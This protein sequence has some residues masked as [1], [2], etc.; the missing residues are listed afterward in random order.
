MD[1]GKKTKGVAKIVKPRTTLKR[2][3][4]SEYDIQL[5][6]PISPTEI[7]R[8]KIAGQWVTHKQC[9]YMSNEYMGNDYYAI[10]FNSGVNLSS[11][12]PIL[13]QDDNLE[14]GI[15]TWVILSLNDDDDDVENKKP[16]MYLKK[17]LS[18]YEFGTKHQEILYHITCKHMQCEKYKLYYAGE[19]LKTGNTIKF[20]LESGTYMK[21]KLNPKKITMGTIKMSK[22][23]AGEMINERLN[24]TGELTIEEENDTFITHESIPLTEN[25]LKIYNFFG[26]KIYKFNNPESCKTFTKRGNSLSLRELGGSIVNFSSLKTG[27]TRSKRKTKRKLKRTKKTRKHKTRKH[28]TRKHKTRKHKT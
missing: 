5:E 18:S 15:Y 25:D 28:K 23:T 3:R 16:R 14:D 7:T 12:M 20:N 19:L 6:K 21:D 22:I 2:K 8:E 26:A 24:K 13:D 1:I 11:T 10:F 9:A 27:G 4:S 17:T